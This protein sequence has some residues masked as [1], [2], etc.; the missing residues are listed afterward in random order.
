[1]PTEI[2]LRHAENWENSDIP[3]DLPMMVAQASSAATAHGSLP[4]IAA[5]VPGF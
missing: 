2:Q 1:M 3:S 4:A 5:T